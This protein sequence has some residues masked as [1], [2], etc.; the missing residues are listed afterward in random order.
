MSTIL[1]VTEAKAKF[2]DVVE[3]AVSG[4]LVEDQ[5]ATY[6]EHAIARAN[7]VTALPKL[8]VTGQPMKRL[9]DFSQVVVA[10]FSA[11]GLFGKYR[12]LFQICSGGILDP[13][14]RH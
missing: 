13:E 5:V 11:P 7:R 6:G 10:L 2:S 3:R 14:T 12:N 4:E 8:G 1:D 9:V